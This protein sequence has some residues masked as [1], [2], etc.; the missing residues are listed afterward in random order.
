MN[1]QFNSFSLLNL[2]EV[3]IN[4]LAA[5]AAKLAESGFSNRLACQISLEMFEDQPCDR[6]GCL[7]SLPNDQNT[8]EPADNGSACRRRGRGLPYFFHRG[9][10]ASSRLDHGVDLQ[11]SRTKFSKADNNL[12]LSSAIPCCWVLS[13]LQE[14]SPGQQDLAFELRL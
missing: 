11:A 4:N 10:C 6:V 7:R 1:A 9:G 13:S 3:G 5:S 14:A 8:G 2:F 12:L